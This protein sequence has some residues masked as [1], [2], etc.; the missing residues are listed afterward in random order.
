MYLY[1]VHRELMQIIKIQNF[2]KELNLEFQSWLRRNGIKSC[3]NFRNGN[4]LR[5]HANNVNV[6]RYN[7]GF[8]G[9]K[10]KFHWLQSNHLTPILRCKFFGR[11]FFFFLH[12]NQVHKLENLLKRT[13]ELS[14]FISASASWCV[15][16]C[17]EMI[18]CSF[19]FYWASWK[20]NDKIIHII[21]WY[22]ISPAYH[23]IS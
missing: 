12:F 20:S 2:R 8:D 14:N 23:R 16:E 6:C 3:E 15:R 18:A 5:S 9:T 22:V 4:F 1:R 13:N 10:S 19:Q 17:D 11:F 7:N 21:Y